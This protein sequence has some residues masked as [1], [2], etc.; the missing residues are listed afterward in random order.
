MT[1][2]VRLIRFSVRVPVLS[3]QMRVVV[4]SVSV[5]LSRRTIAPCAARRSDPSPRT[6]TT[7]TGSSAGTLAKA[8]VSPVSRRSRSGC[9][10]VSHPTAG[11]SRLATAATT[12]SRRASS[13]IW[14][15]SGVFC[16]S[17]S[18]TSEATRPRVEDWPTAVTVAT[19]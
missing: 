19:A 11:T 14:P 1:T 8:S 2:W 18:P 7:S 3:V 6:A 4:P 17:A 15:W 12:R 16:G 5:A 13:D 9:A 10:A